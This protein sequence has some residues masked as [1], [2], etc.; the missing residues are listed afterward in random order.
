[1]KVDNAIKAIVLRLK[2]DKFADGAEIIAK[3]HVPG[4]LNARKNPLRSEITR[5]AISP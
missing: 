3:M 5:H 2:V 1:V 4:R